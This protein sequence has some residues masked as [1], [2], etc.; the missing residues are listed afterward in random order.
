M[1]EPKLGLRNSDSVDKV[2]I[3]KDAPVAQLD[4]AFDYELKTA[5]DVL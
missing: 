3:L 4:R 5:V 2:L 1:P